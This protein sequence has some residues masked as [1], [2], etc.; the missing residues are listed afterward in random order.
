MTE[1]TECEKLELQVKELQEEI[2]ALTSSHESQRKQLGKQVK[3]EKALRDKIWKELEQEMEYERLLSEVSMMFAHL[4]AKEVDGEIKEVIRRVADMF[5]LDRGSF[6]QY[7]KDLGQIHAT[8]SWAGEGLPEFFDISEGAMFVTKQHFPWVT[9]TMSHQETVAFSNVDDLP[10]E[11]EKDKQ[12]FK[13]LGVKSGIAIPYFIEGSFLFTVTFGSIHPGRTFPED[14]IHRL[15]RLGEVFSNAILRKNADEEIQKAFSEIRE[16]KDRLQEENIFLLKEIKTIRK[17]PEI[18]GESDVIKTV[19]AK[20]EQ[21]AQRNTTVLILGE[22]GTGKE[23]VARAIH[24]FSAR[25]NHPMV[26]VNCAGLPATLVE[27]EL[28][29]R[30]KG[31]YTGALSKQIGRFEIADGSTI[32]LDEIGELPMELQ[33]KL[34]RVLERGQFERLG[35]S[36]TLSVD[37]RVIAA[38]NRD[39]QK[40][41]EEVSFREDLYYRL[42]VFPIQIPPL[43]ERPEDIL[44]LTWAFIKEFSH[45]MG[46]QIDSIPKRSLDAMKRYP[47]PGNIRELKNLIERAMIESKGKTLIVKLPER[48][49]AKVT[50]HLTMEQLERKHIQEVLEKT[51]WR[52]R[53]RSGAAEI[54]GLK[55]STLY[56]RM[57]KLGVELRRQHPD[58]D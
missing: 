28:F 27:A 21:V 8:H 52:I 18:I 36:R 7:S 13:K 10:R 22:T 2:H 26:T 4:P 44:P 15:R 38:T 47:W 14:M 9:E 54:L 46:K 50:H 5:E 19:L 23:L 42:N 43:R 57:K 16:L 39:L 58:F 12:T 17:H 25:K 33:V 6:M 32:F 34:L 45:A 29:G 37:V 11:A 35:S 24:E 40:A 1:K 53:G 41:I 31:A 55:P 20:V 49:S 30:E 3:F 51:R 56:A 48:H